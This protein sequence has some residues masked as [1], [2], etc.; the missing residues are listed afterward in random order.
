MSDITPIFGYVDV[1][2][3]SGKKSKEMALG[4]KRAMLGKTPIFAIPLSSAWLYNEPEY[5]A[6]ATRNIAEFLGMF[7][8]TFLLT[9]IAQLILNYLP[10]LIE[11][12]PFDAQ[13]GQ[14]CG[15]GKLTM[16]GKTEYFGITTTGRIL[17]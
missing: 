17:K 10:D 2:D 11:S 12:K 4:I 6:R 14:E 8:D 7:P 15:E 13:K 16:D 3:A 5:M 9:R 1:T